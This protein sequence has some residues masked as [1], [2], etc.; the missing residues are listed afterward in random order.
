MNQYSKILL[1]A[2]IAAAGAMPAAAVPAKPGVLTV[3]QADGSELR[4]RLVGDERSHFYMTEDGYLLSNDKDIYY[5]AGI[6]ATGRLQSSGIRAADVQLRDGVARNYL[7]GVDMERVREAMTLQAQRDEAR[8]VRKSVS[9]HAAAHGNP[10]LFPG[11][12]FPSMGEQKAIVI[13]VDYQD[14]KF[15]SRYDAF[16]YFNRMLNEPGFS[17]YGG[18]GS[19]V[20]FFTESSMGQ[21]VPQFDVYGPLTLKNKRS[22]YGGNDYYGNDRHPEEMVIEACQQLDATV[23]FSEY[24][25]DGDGFID[26]VFIFYAGEGE[27]SGGASETVWPHSWNIS[28]ATSVSYEFDGVRLDR[29]GCSN[30]WEEPR[31]GGGGSS[32]PDGVGTFVHEFS[33]VMGLPD[34][35]AT[36]YTSSFTPGSWSA[37]DYGP[38]NNDGC[39]PPLYSAFERYALGWIDPLPIDGAVNATLYPIGTNQAGIIRTSDPDEF[40]LVENRQQTGW[41]EF[42]PGH[43][44]LV[45]HVDYNES[46]WDSNKVNNT[47]SH[48]Y[49]D[50][51]E[52]DG[53]KSETTRA[54]DSFPGTAGT[55]SFT[56]TTNPSMKTW[57]GQAL[58]LPITDIA[59]SASG[60]ITFKVCGGREPMGATVAEEATD[61]TFESFTA[62]WQSAGDDKPYVLSVCTAGGKF[63]PGYESLRVQGATSCSVTGLQPETEYLYTVAVGDGW[64]V[65]PASNEISVT[66]TRTP[67]THRRVEA[68]DAADVAADGFTARWT[69]IDDAESYLL[70]VYT[71]EWGEP[72]HEVCDFTGGVDK[73]PAGWTST[74]GG[75]Y[76]NANYSGQAIPA[77][78]L[79]VTGDAITSPVYEGGVRTL[80]FWHR[81]NGSS[82]ADRVDV[83]A[84]TNG[85]WVI[86]AQITVLTTK[87]GT[88]TTI[89][90]EEM[91]AGATQLRIEYVRTGTKGAVAIDDI[92]V[93]YGE[94]FTPVPVEGLADYPAGTG[95]ECSVSGLD[96]D[97]EY[98][99]T[100]RAAA[101][102]LLSLPSNEIAVR[103]AK[104]SGIS[105]A[106]ACAPSLNL[107]GLVLS[108]SGAAA[109]APFNVADIAGRIV[110]AAT[111][112]SDGTA[113]VRLPAP[114]I[115]IA[116]S[117]G[118][119]V[120]IIAR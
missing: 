18:T 14:V 34:L 116:V 76:A 62:R 94:T 64:E 13:L 82:P 55:T 8:S 57:S 105:D 54:G 113:A 104:A 45:W 84:F 48:Q 37:L 23:D 58:G 44:M 79:G 89:G 52:A 115:Y 2:I 7:A 25:R 5:Y 81:G 3:T 92:T 66:T 68:T 6:D 38:Y 36:S 108:I 97:T 120:K 29:Y 102:G 103:T 67:L 65:S 1:S 4:V 61:V 9:M 114:G 15:N 118:L 101:D 112:C 85:K 99:Y 40:F 30:E 72:M 47:A 10:G 109:G 73:L 16:D 91:P 22:Y 106:T 77:L 27:A 28:Y 11:T 32:R 41:D 110:A 80:S 19:A 74:T 46:V 17:D 31:I 26:N 59:E 51:E 88:V 75:S 98:F 12:H 21:F 95:S 117:E 96:A 42:I 107:D 70:T 53:L 83:S 50:L 56:D 33:H 78:R 35:Y 63:V 111:V 93:G 39:T 60:I 86:V 90:E 119:R 20:D 24:D 49:V 100:V 87:G 69:A 71:K 43:G